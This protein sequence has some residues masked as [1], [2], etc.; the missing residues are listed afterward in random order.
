[1]IYTMISSSRANYFQI[2]GKA[3]YYAK[4]SPGVGAEDITIRIFKSD[5]LPPIWSRVFKQAKLKDDKDELS[6]L[7]KRFESID[8]MYRDFS[9]LWEQRWLNQKTR[10]P[11]KQRANS[12]VQFKNT[13]N[14]NRTPK[15]C[16]NCENLDILK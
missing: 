1:M 13:E 5:M 7:A 9:G 11:G 3:L 6:A 10:P 12:R 16:F 15:K 2:K 8:L 4:T 14:Y